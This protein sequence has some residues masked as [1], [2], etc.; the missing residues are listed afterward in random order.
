MC[1]HQRDGLAPGLLSNVLLLILHSTLV[2]LHADRVARV[3]VPRVLR[4]T[5]RA[6]LLRRLCL[7]SRCAT[8]SENC[9]RCE[10]EESEPSWGDH[11]FHA[12]VPDQL[13][14]ARVWVL[15]H[16]GGLV[17]PKLSAPYLCSTRPT[18]ERCTKRWPGS[19][20]AAMTVPDWHARLVCSR[21][22]GRR[23]VDFAATGTERR[24]A[25]RREQCELG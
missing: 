8:R 17:A 1:R 2:G 20:W 24:R 21:N 14:M 25:D 5:D 22:C 3:A 4:D 23:R 7:A 6:F 15:H 9:T 18:F 13:L 10:H 16:A 11:Q 12:A 19:S